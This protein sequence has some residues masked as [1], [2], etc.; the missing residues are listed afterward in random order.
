M[1]SVWVQPCLSVDLTFQGCQPP[2]PRAEAG[3]GKGRVSELTEETWRRQARM[4]LG[5]QLQGSRCCR[6]GYRQGAGASAG[7]PQPWAASLTSHSATEADEP[8]TH[9]LTAMCLKAGALNP[10]ISQVA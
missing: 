6:A 5:G 9:L 1:E 7:Q 4:G 3:K 2:A 8:D 10:L